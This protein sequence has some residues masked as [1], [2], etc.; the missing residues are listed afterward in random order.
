VV[1]PEP[2]DT[3]PLL[4]WRADHLRLGVLLLLT[5]SDGARQPTTVRVRVESAPQGAVRIVASTSVPLRA[6]RDTATYAVLE[7]FAAAEGGNISS[8][9]APDGTTA[10]EF[11]LPGLSS[12]SAQGEA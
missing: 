11:S 3:S 9:A 10:L 7:T 8:A 6:V 1:G 2:S 12:A 4:L 5:V